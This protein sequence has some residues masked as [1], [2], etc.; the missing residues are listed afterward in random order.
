MAVKNVLFVSLIFF[1]S[2]VLEA[3]IF[4]GY[5]LHMDGAEPRFSQRLAW[6]G[7]GYTLRYEVVI[8]REEGEG[9]RPVRREF[10]NDSFLEVELAPGMYRFRVIP[11]DY[12][13]RPGVGSEWVDI[14]VRSALQPEL[15]AEEPEF[16]SREDNALCELAVSGRNIDTNAEICLLRSDGEKI[17]PINVIVFAGSSG[18]RLIY[19]K[20]ALP[21]GVYD[22]LV[23]NPGGL[24]ASRKGI[25]IAYPEPEPEIEPEPEPV[26]HQRL[27][28]EYLLAAWM[29]LFPVYG[30]P[31]GLG[32]ESMDAALTGAAFRFGILST[33]FNPLNAGL[34]LTCSWHAFGFD[35]KS[36]QTAA[37]GLNLVAEKK[38]SGQ[39]AALR[40]RLG[41]GISMSMG[42]EKPDSMRD[43]FN[44]TMGVSF[45]LPVKKHF[46]T[47]IGIDYTHRFT[48]IPTGALKPW[49]GLGLQF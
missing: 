6:K 47:E 17:V 7:D 27:H 3:Q 25:V 40:F 16:I 34:E 13:N 2:S 20:S 43:S 42:E 45:Y 48:D 15:D 22:I 28:S 4:P 37:F 46:C 44:T 38:L 10:T 32:Q 26:K 30:E 14:E 9:Y 5:F 33:T 1:L 11:Y 35:S 12:L 49:L 23:E 31:F 8:E 36:Q 39:A 41:A 19:Y 21:E 24:T 18:A 29:P